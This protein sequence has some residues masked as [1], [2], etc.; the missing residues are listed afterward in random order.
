MPDLEVGAPFEPSGDQPKAISEL[1]EGV[2]K[3]IKYQTLMGA[4]GTGKTFTISKVI[5]ALQKPTIV[6]SHNKTLAAQLYGEFK[7]FFPNN[8]V[9]YFISYY[10]Y[11]QPEAYKPVTDTYIEKE[12]D[13]NDEIN[14]LRLRATSQLQSRKD[15]IIVASV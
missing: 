15:V 9:E 4:T 7:A 5:E 6:I 2:E 14:R 13:I 8:A 11:Y 12:V 10:D 3:G 1:I